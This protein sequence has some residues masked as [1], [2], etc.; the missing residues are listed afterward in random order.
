MAGRRSVAAA[1]DTRVA[2][3][4]AAA[5]MASIDGLDGLTVGRLA[6][7]LGMSK[8]GVI[9]HFGSKTELQLATIEYAADVFRAEVWTP[10]EHLE[11]GLPRLLA[12]C[13]AW[14]AYAG[15]PAFPGGCFFAAASFEYD[16]KTGPV[17]DAIAERVQRWHERLSADVATAIEAGELPTDASADRIAHSLWALAASVTPNR[18]LHRDTDAADHVKT[19]M[20]I[21][22]GAR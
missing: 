10:A 2:I 11:P 18:H 8:A 3:L 15:K 16:S 4:R 19:S 22:L 6:S 17:H 5:D 9:G 21:L 7:E 13:D 20:R 12:I 1:R 14:M